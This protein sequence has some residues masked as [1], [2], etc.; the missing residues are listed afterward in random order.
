MLIEPAD[1]CL[2]VLNFNADVFGLKAIRR[3]ACRFG[4]QCYVLI[5]QHARETKVQLISK[6]CCGSSSAFMNQ[7]CNEVLEQELRERVAAEMVGVRNFLLGLALAHTPCVSC[8]S[9]I[10]T[11]PTIH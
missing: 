5:E 3:A 2:Q 9:A 8:A 10:R 6:E 1:S 11:Q 4:S 7:F